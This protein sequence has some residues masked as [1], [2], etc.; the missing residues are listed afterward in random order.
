[1]SRYLHKTGVIFRYSEC[2][3]LISLAEI[4]TYRIDVKTGDVK[5]AGTD[6]NVYIILYGEERYTGQLAV[7]QAS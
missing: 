3:S 6:A 2:E 5:W 4:M 7:A 1:M